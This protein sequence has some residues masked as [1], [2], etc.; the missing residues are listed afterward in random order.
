MSTFTVTNIDE[1]ESLI[2]QLA[3]DDVQIELKSHDFKP[4][5]PKVSLK[6]DGD[7]ERLNGEINSTLCRGLTEFHNSL[8]KAYCVLK[9]NDTNLNKLTKEERILLEV[10]YTFEPGCTKIIAELTPLFEAIKGALDGAAAVMDGMSGNQKTAVFISTVLT[11][12]G[13]G[14]FSAVT[15]MQANDNAHEEAMAEIAKD[16]AAENGRQKTLSDMNQQYLD[17][18][19]NVVEQNYQALDRVSK[20]TEQRD[21]GYQELVKTAVLAGSTEIQYDG[22]EHGTISQRQAAEIITHNKPRWKR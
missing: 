16:Q 21:K 17:T 4:I 5:Y 3:N 1:L 22:A 8:L 15:E 12:G 18:L 20:V 13:Y 7:H 11:L 19:E 6:L 2:S 10:S 14:V 9:Y